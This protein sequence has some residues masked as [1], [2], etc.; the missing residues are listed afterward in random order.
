MFGADTTGV[1]VS[2]VPPLVTDEP[3]VFEPELDPDPWPLTDVEDAIGV[4]VNVVPLLVTEEVG[5][6]EPEL[7]VKLSRVL[8]VEVESVEEPVL[9]ENVVGLNNVVTKVTKT[10]VTDGVPFTVVVLDVA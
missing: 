4:G 10:T 7:L 1:G 3:G 8:L 5:L 9:V 6:F 2:V